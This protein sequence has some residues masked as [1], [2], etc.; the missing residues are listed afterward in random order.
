MLRFVFEQADLPVGS[1]TDNTG[2]DK[3]LKRIWLIVS[4]PEMKHSLHEA[5]SAQ[6]Q[7]INRPITFRT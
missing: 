4:E 6:A 2:L 3:D 1:F 5:F 7:F